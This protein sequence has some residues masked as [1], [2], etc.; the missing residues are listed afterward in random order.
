LHAGIDLRDAP[1]T[2]EIPRF[3]R[4]VVRSLLGPR[5]SPDVPSEDVLLM[6]VAVALSLAVFVAILR[7]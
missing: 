3:V 5:P 6:S 7:P 2:V 4:I 1:A